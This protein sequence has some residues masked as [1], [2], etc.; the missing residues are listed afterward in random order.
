MT[1]TA[2]SVCANGN[3]EIGEG[4][5]QSNDKSARQNVNKALGTMA[6][7]NAQNPPG[8]DNS[9]MADSALNIM[10]TVMEKPLTTNATTAHEKGANARI[11]V[12]IK[13]IIKL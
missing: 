7:Y 12:A 6:S 10:L 5:Y 3:R 13:V 4:K 1:H 8:I 9:E 2:I 11:P